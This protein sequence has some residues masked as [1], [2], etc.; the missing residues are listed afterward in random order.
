MP[1]IYWCSYLR[2]AQEALYITEIS[3]YQNIYDVTTGLKLFG[4]SLDHWWWNY[5][6]ITLFG[7]FYRVLAYISLLIW[8]SG[9]VKK[10][11]SSVTDFRRHWILLKQCLKKRQKVQRSDE[12][13]L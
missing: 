5:M 8:S 11:V 1:Y 4:Y 10:I 7:L 9:I 12:I 13:V 3:K 6:S 2:Y